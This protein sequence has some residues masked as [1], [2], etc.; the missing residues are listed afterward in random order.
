MLTSLSQLDDLVKSRTQ[1]VR[2]AVVKGA[3]AAVIDSLA[4]LVQAGLVHPLLIDSAPELARLAAAQLP[5]GKYTLV[6]VPDAEA[7]REGVRLVRCGEAEALMKGHVTSG[8]FLKAVVDREVGIRASR[9]LSHVAVMQA[10]HLGRLIA[11][12][13]GGMVPVPD[14]DQLEAI[15][16]HGVTVMRALGHDEVKVALLSAAESPIPHLPSAQLQATFAAE[17]H[18]FLVEGPLS[19][20]IAL[21]PGIAAEKGYDGKIRG[22]ATVVVAPNIV[23]GNVLAKSLIYFGGGAMAGIVLGASCPIILTSRSAG[24]D[25]KRYSIQL[26][27]VL[28]TQASLGKKE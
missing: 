12:T 24:A 10:E 8:A 1:P 6:D 9:V 7:P 14:A 18:D 5:S 28:S 4:D 2:I 23:T 15:V 27:M 19:L 21:V 11:V 25:E 20:D 16:D 26:A 22:D 13:D 3:D 17:P